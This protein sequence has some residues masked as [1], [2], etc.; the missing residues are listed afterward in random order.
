VI[1]VIALRQVA[2]ATLEIASGL[3]FWL[4]SKLSPGAVLYAG[5]PSV[6]AAVIVGIVPAL[7]ATRGEVQAG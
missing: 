6:L 4:S 1:A 3:P 7:Q 2:A 5:M